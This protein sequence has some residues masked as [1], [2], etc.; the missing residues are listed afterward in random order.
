MTAGRSIQRI[1]L[2]T[3]ILFLGLV[4]ITAAQPDKLEGRWEGTVLAP[5]GQFPAH[6]SFKKEADGYR[7]TVS[8][9]R[10]DLVFKEIKVDGNRV[11]AIAEAQTLQGNLPVSYDF[12]IDGEAL[13][14]KAEVS[15]AG[16][17]F[18]FIFDLKRISTEPP[19]LQAAAPPALPPARE[20]RR[21][22]A[23]QPLQQQRLEYFQGQWK[24]KWLARESLLGPGGSREGTVTYTPILD[25]KFLEGR[26]EG[27]I[28]GIDFR[29]INYLTWDADR[30]ILTSFEQRSVG[31]A[32]LGLGDWTSPIAIR[33]T[34]A[35]VTVKGQTL[36]LKK[37]VNIVAAHSFSVT[38]E[39]SMNGGPFQ[40]LGN[41]VFTR[42]ETK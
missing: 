4:S 2:G 16:Q 19:V 17:N 39:L 35:P 40:R 24:F 14:G 12:L 28:E 8:G 21:E 23:P 32:I 26:T 20:T 38:E 7:G 29:E 5:Q 42:V 27:K 11:T 3:G 6:A 25:G 1:K 22:P 31:A 30:K 9:L 33:F 34:V 10:G 15:F 36:Q 37:I 18:T 13:K 41:G